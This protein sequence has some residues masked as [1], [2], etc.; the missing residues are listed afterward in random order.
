M[1]GLPA[2]ME[3]IVRGDGRPVA[4]MLV[5][6]SF[7][8]TKKNRHAYLAGPSDDD[9]RIHVR[10]DD[11]VNWARE[12]TS[13]FQMDYAGLESHFAGKIEATPVGPAEIEPILKG[14]YLYETA[15]KFPSNYR[16]NAI[17][18]GEKLRELTGCNLNVEV[19]LPPEA[20][21]IVAFANSIV[22]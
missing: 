4:G 14:H 17:R 2:S 18:A 13:V 15:L 8:M 9:G 16:D 20:Q 21:E 5:T 7:W 6:L 1:I 22:V 19:R 3:L 11:V 12:E 10:R